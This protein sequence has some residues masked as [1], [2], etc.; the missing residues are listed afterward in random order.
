MRTLLDC[1]NEDLVVCSDLMHLLE[2][3]AVITS[4]LLVIAV[5]LI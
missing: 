3:D 4:S 2:V 1:E 5:L